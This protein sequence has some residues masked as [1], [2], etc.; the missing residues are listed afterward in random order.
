MLHC[1]VCILLVPLFNFTSGP[2][3]GHSAN[4]LFVVTEVRIVAGFIPAFPNGFML[5]RPEDSVIFG[6]A[7]EGEAYV[8][9]SK[10]G[11]QLV[12]QFAHFPPALLDESAGFKFVGD[13]GDLRWREAIVVIT[14]VLECAADGELR[15]LAAVHVVLKAESL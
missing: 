5:D 9:I 6:W 1:R 10:S 13:D 14:D 2:C 3:F 7:T 4:V 11:D 8:D 12:L 15:G